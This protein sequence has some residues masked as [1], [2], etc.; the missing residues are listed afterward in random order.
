MKRGMKS[1]PVTAASRRL[2]SLAEAARRSGFTR[3]ALEADIGAGELRAVRRDG[4]LF[5][6]PA[7]VAKC[8][9]YHQAVARDLAA[10]QRDR[11]ARRV[12]G[13]FRSSAEHRAHVAGR[14][15]RP[16]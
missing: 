3:A 15:R 13:P 1:N 10:S 8:V 9:R 14:R 16:E 11:A 5:V 7:A 2:L 4:E 12:V 6:T